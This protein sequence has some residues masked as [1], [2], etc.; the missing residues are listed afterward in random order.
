MPK[1]PSRRELLEEN[2]QLRAKI[3][4]YESEDNMCTHLI[5]QQ[6]I[7]QIARDMANKLS[8]Q[9]N[10]ITNDVAVKKENENAK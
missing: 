6:H 5:S 4:C 7:A 3:R 1:S 9:L 2:S 8:E 10:Q